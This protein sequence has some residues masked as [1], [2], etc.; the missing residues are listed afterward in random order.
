MTSKDYTKA[1]NQLD[2][3]P[4]KKIK[5]LKHNKP[6]ERKYGRSK[7]K[8]HITKNTHGVIQMYG[9]NICRR[10]F[11]KFAKELGFKKYS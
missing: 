3:K 11:R 4:G 6:K 10:H 5:Y 9:L 2:N 8:C 7:S 1:F